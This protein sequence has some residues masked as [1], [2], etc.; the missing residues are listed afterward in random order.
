MVRVYRDGDMVRDDDGNVVS[1]EIIK[2]ED[3]PEEASKWE[4]RSNARD[5]VAV[6]K[7]ECDESASSYA[8]V[9]AV[10]EAVRHGKVSDEQIDELDASV[11]PVQR[12]LEEAR[13]AAD[14]KVTPPHQDVSAPGP[15]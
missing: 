5:A 3:M 9:G 7:R 1:P 14:H 8:R 15:G 12:H 11:E 2:A 13:E 10:K 6:V 4:E